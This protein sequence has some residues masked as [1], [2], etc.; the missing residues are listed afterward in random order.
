MD[1]HKF[2]IVIL[3][4]VLLSALVLFLPKTDIPITFKLLIAVWFGAYI[5]TPV[6]SYLDN[7]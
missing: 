5:R 7:N 2:G 6:M 3:Y 4:V 1:Y